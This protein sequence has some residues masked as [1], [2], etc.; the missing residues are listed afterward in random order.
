MFSFTL[1]YTSES[2]QRLSFSLLRK[3]QY[4]LIRKRNSSIINERKCWNTVVGLEVHAQILAKSK[5]FSGASTTY[6]SPVNSNVSFFDAA[7]PGTLPVLNRRCVEAAVITGLALSCKINPVSS[8]D[9]KHYFYADLPAGYQITQQREPIAQDG[10]LSFQV[11]TPGIHKKPYKK[12]SKIKQLQLEQDSGKSLHDD[13]EKISLVDLNRAGIPLMEIVFEPDLKD[14]EEAA[15]L[16]KELS[17]ILQRLRTCSCKMEEGALRV[18]ANVS[19]NKEGHPLGT[20]TEIKNIASIRGVA[21][22]V[23]FEIQ[24]QISIVSQG[25]VIENETRAWD[26]LQKQTVPMRDKEVKQDY[27]YMPEP[28][29][30]PLRLHVEGFPPPKDAKNLINVKS[31]RNQLPEMP[32]ETRQKLVNTYGLPFESAINLVNNDTLLQYFFQIMES[33][34]RD[35]KLAA[36]ILLMNYLETLNKN[37]I[38]IS[39]CSLPSKS[40]GIVIDLLQEKKINQNI[41]KMLL[42]EL[43]SVPNCSP[44]QIIEEKGWILITDENEIR[45]LCEDILLNNPKMVQQYKSGKS[46]VFNAFVG[47]VAKQTN[48]SV[49]MKT[50]VQEFKKLLS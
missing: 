36:N 9:R 26:A 22:A 33:K 41:A 29:L 23:Q 12:S 3:L 31:L 10:E 43:I 6:A 39:E 38:P 35:S 27:R 11:F 15:A 49:C 5:L 1:I 45:K 20:R 13:I 37:K 32:E 24:R 7:T 48:Q 16:I 18:D 14:G 40:L 34:G 42:N 21:N 50:V 2:F 4:S 47:L 8:F 30:P 28:N 25:G 17:I 19:I 44:L 46:K